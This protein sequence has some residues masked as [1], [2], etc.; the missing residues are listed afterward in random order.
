VDDCQAAKE[1]SVQSSALPLE[2]DVQANVTENLV[3]NVEVQVIVSS[4]DVSE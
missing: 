1:Y 4:K 3:S 2:E